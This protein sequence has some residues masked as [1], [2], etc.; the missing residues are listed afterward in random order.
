MT[1]IPWT[2][3]YRPKELSNVVY[4][5]VIIKTLEKSIVDVTLSHLLF[6]G[7]PGTGKTSTILALA[8]KL[9]GKYLS[10][11]VLELNAS[12]N[13]GIDIVR[14]TIKDFVNTKGILSNKKDVPKLIILDEA[15]ELTIDAQKVLKKIMEKYNN[16]VR[17][18]LICN[19]INGIILSLQSRCTKFRFSTI[20]NDIVEK[21]IMNICIQE[22]IKDYTGIKLLIK[23]TK[24]DLRKSINM[25]NIISLINGTL[26]EEDVINNLEI[27]DNNKLLEIIKMIKTNPIKVSFANLITLIKND[28]MSFQN[29]IIE[30]QEY[31]VQLIINLNDNDVNN[32]LNIIENLGNF[33]MN[34]INT[35]NESLQLLGL[36]STIKKYDVL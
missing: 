6:Y 34:I 12:N 2:E 19:N 22:N 36:I 24:G 32:Y 25:L 33:E 8:N 23:T 4:H 17:F 11:Y 21:I 26:T 1:S 15:D 9:Y 18:C 31:Y 29:L 14:S 20:P 30:L 13:R 35:T 5:N 28:N 3:K 16:N 10:N 27:I 7:P